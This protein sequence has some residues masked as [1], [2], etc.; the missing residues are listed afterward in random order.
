MGRSGAMVSSAPKASSSSETKKKLDRVS[1]NILF[2]FN[3]KH[4]PRED[5]TTRDDK[6][7][8]AVHASAGPSTSRRPEGRE[9]SERAAASEPPPPPPASGTHRWRRRE[10]VREENKDKPTLLETKLAA[11]GRTKRSGHVGSDSDSDDGGRIDDIAALEACVRNARTLVFSVH[12]SESNDHSKGVSECL[13]ETQAALEAYQAGGSGR[14]KS[15][16]RTR[17]RERETRALCDA[18]KLQVLAAL[19]RHTYTHLKTEK[20]SIILSLAHAALSLL[21]TNLSV[22]AGKEFTE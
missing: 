7:K 9:E 22:N 2:G 4:Q 13:S 19:W 8:R 15:R 6:E 18:I 12:N 20:D 10:P 17:R 16:K 5:V 3:R 11:S 14:R 21:E 1:S